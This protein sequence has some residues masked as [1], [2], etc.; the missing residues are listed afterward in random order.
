[1]TLAK[2]SDHKDLRQV[3]EV[4][5]HSPPERLE[6][7][8][9][10]EQVYSFDKIDECLIN[11]KQGHSLTQAAKTPVAIVAAS[12]VVVTDGSRTR[13]FHRPHSGFIFCY[14]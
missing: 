14:I 1:M 4:N 7:R 10:A 3:P 8:I 6:S 12:V 13:A 11:W 9:R 5:S 2:V